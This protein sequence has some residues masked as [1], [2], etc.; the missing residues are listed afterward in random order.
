MKEKENDI[1]PRNQYQNI[2]KNESLS[3]TPLLKEKKSKED[4]SKN[5]KDYTKKMFDYQKNI[6]SEDINRKHF[7]SQRHLYDHKSPKTITLVNITKKELQTEYIAEVHYIFKRIIF[8]MI[9]S[10]ITF[11]QSLIILHNYK[12]YTEVILSQIF[13][14]F[15]FFISF[16]L[17]VEI[18]R[19]ALRDQFR[20]NLF[21]LFSIFLS[22]FII[23]LIA[24]E[25]MNTNIIYNKIKVRK[26]KCQKDKRH[27]GD[28]NANYVILALGAI[29]I[30]GFIFI[31]NFPIYLGFRSIKILFGYDYEVY[32][33]Q[34][35]ENEKENKEVDKKEIKNHKENSSKI[36]KEH[37]KNE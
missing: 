37:F 10:I 6:Y 31:F 7:L 20:N 3:S 36:K 24:S 22:V 18:Y 12:N 23:C 15:T 8:S 5:K 11:I 4:N 21:R 13:S 26:E 29:H 2:S 17:I 25:I 14:A 33:R 35:I 19:D 34:M 30:I 9:I 28:T 32:Q 27:C 16:F 1:K